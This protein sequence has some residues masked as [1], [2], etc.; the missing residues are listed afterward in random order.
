MEH[1]SRIRVMLH[2]GKKY[3]SKLIAFD[4][5]TDIAIIKI[6]ADHLDVIP[7]ADSDKIKV[8]DVVLAIGNPFSIGK[9]VSQGIISAV[10]KRRI[11]LQQ[12]EQFILTDSA[13]NQGSS[14]GALVNSVGLLVGMNQGIYSRDE[15]FQGVAIVVPSNQLKYEIDQLIK[16][17]RISRGSLGLKLQTITKSL[18]KNLSLIHI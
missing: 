5:D 8:G 17:G 16:Y 6:N 12:Y 4:A 10:N 3:N 15:G 14:G 9:S 13:I 7:F 18:R 11:G 1:A 2:N